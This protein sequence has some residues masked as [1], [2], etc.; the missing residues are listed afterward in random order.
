MPVRVDRHTMAQNIVVKGCEC[1]V[2]PT[3]GRVA[4]PLVPVFSLSFITDYARQHDHVPGP[5]L[6][7]R[8]TFVPL[9]TS[10]YFYTPDA[11]FQYTF[12]GLL[13]K[14]HAPAASGTIWGP[15]IDW[16]WVQST[17]G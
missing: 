3:A 17:K 9:F 16:Q 2:S 1:E 10:T 8:P 12:D 13:R 4:V 5:I 11:G 7:T 15:R 6:V 14:R